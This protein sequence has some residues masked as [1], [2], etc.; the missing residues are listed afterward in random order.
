MD[1]E[2][3]ALEILFALNRLL[4]VLVE[5]VQIDLRDFRVCS[6]DEC[7]LTCLGLAPIGKK[8]AQRRHNA[9]MSLLARVLDNVNAELNDVP[10][11]DLKWL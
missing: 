11:A 1:V 5:S 8:E 4:N 2:Q 7:R 3:L 9:S 6:T 10:T